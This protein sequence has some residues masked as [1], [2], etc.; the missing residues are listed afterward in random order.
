MLNLSWR[1]L[2]SSCS[3]IAV[4]FSVPGTGISTSPSRLILIS[5]LK[6]FLKCRFIRSRSQRMLSCRVGK[7]A[8]GWGRFRVSILLRL[9][10]MTLVIFVAL[11][12]VADWM[13]PELIKWFAGRRGQTLLSTQD[14]RFLFGLGAILI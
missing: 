14:A 11:Y 1:S 3:L 7:S 9:A 2:M 5:A 8:M 6:W 10:V 12:L 13:G 4:F